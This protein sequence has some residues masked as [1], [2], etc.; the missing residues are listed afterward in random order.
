[1]SG[2]IKHELEFSRREIKEYVIS[3]GGS[4]I[5][6]NTRWKSTCLFRQSQAVQFDEKLACTEGTMKRLEGRFEST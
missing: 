5:S 3:R 1:M 6:E 2:D 4:A